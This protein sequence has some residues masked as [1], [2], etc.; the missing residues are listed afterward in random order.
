MCESMMCVPW[1]VCPATCS[2]TTRS[3]GTAREV[4]VRIEAVV[5]GRDEDVVHVEEQRAVGLLGQPREELP[6]GHLPRRELD[7]RRRILEGERRAEEVLHRA[8]ARRRRAEAP[9]RCT[10]SAGGRACSCRRRPSSTDGR[11]PSAPRPVAQRAE[12][13]RYAR[14]SGSVDPMD[15]DTPCIDDRILRRRWRRAKSQ[16]P[17]RRLHVVL[18]EDLEPVD[19]GLGLE[20]VRVV[21][22]PQAE[23]H[24]EIGEAEAIGHASACP[25]LFAGPQV[26]LQPP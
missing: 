9:P 11:T 20:D 26:P 21:H 19:L 16:R 14:S 5:E 18:A 12:L 3:N 22:G 13:L 15:S 17:P 6:L 8:H 1:W 2:W 7:V 24:A 10:A 4:L 25:R 23:T